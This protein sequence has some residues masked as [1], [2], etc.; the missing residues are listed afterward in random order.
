MHN[1]VYEW[2]KGKVPR[3]YTVDHKNRNGFD[4]RVCNLRKATATQQLYNTGPRSDN[5]SGYRGVFWHKGAKK[6]MV[7]LKKH[8][9]YFYGGVHSKKKEACKIAA[10]IYQELAEEFAT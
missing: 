10:Q 3:G 6:W 9:E 5:I 4:N 7:Q 1:L 8:H 2:S